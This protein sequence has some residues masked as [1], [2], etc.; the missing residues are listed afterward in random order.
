MVRVPMAAILMM[1]EAAVP[2]RPPVSL[3]DFAYGDRNDRQSIVGRAA[4][5]G[6]GDLRTTNLASGDEEVRVWEGFGVT[7]LEGV[8]LR[9]PSH[10]ERD[11]EPLAAHLLELGRIAG[12]VETA[13]IYADARGR[14][15]AVRA[16]GDRRAGGFLVFER[17]GCGGLIRVTIYL[18]HQKPLAGSG[19][20]IQL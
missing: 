14:L 5:S 7:L 3:L 4:L 10:P 9:D 2:L 18:A 20:R 19:C 8:V 12:S 11:H 15:V 16:E 1:L 17:D 13:V 6:Y